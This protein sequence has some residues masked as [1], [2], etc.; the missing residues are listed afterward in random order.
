MHD[1]VELVQLL[2]YPPCYM[3]VCVMLFGLQ[4]IVVWLHGKVDDGVKRSNASDALWTEMC[5][6]DESETGTCGEASKG[7]AVNVVDVRLRKDVVD[8]V[9]GIVNGSG[10]RMFWRFAVVGVD[11]N[12][13]R[14]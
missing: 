6:N 11:E 4:R 7:D 13:V 12:A 1:L 10:E 2:W 3:L 9:D 5:T 8:D 14:A